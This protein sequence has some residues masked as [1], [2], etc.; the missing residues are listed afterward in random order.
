MA[1]NNAI[2]QNRPIALAAARFNAITGA[3]TGDGS[4]YNIAFNT[5]IYD[6]TNSML[7]GVFTAPVSGL[8]YIICYIYM[9]NVASNHTL[10]VLTVGKAGNYLYSL[11]NPGALKTE[12]N[13]SDI[14]LSGILVLSAGD[15]IQSNITVSGGAKTVTLYGNPT[16]W[17]GNL[18]VS[19]I[20]N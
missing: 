8:Y 4:S 18:Q 20:S 15:V 13:R 10:A 9:A 14:S 3:V 19:L 16:N 7:N 6:T 12:I 17:Y 2:N 11:N 5:N 1:T